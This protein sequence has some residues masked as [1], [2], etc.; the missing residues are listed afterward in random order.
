MVERLSIG[1]RKRGKRVRKG[2]R[3]YVYYQQEQIQHGFMTTVI[4]MVR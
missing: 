3:L 1:L 4:G 2:V